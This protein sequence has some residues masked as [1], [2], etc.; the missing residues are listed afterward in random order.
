MQGVRTTRGCVGCR[1]RKKGCDLRKPICGRCS[2]LNITCHYEDQRLIFVDDGPTARS[3]VTAGPAAPSATAP[4]SIPMSVSQ[5]ALTRTNTQLQVDA[6]FWSIY[7]TK[8][9]PSL[10]GS[11]DGITSAPWI[12][13]V[14]SLAETDSHLRKTL[15]ALEFAGL[16]WVRDDRS[17]VQHSLRLYT[18]ALKE[19]NRALQNVATAQRDATLA[20]CRLLGLFEMLQRSSPR[21]RTDRTQVTDWQSHVDGTCRLIQL[22]GRDKHTSGHGLNLYDSIRITSIIHGIARRRPNAFT[23]LSWDLARPRTLKDE[24][25]DLM[26]T[27]PNLFQSIDRVNAHISGGDTGE[28]DTE[29]FCLA[30][31]ELLQR[32]LSTVDHLRAWEA[33]ALSLC[34]RDVP[35]PGSDAGALD[36]SNTLADVCLYHGEGFFFVC[37]QYWAMCVKMYTAN[38]L[39]YNQISS[40]FR[41]SAPGM[42]A[43]IPQLSDW[44]DPEP[45]AV[46]IADTTLHFFRSDAGLW[47]AQSAVFPV[48]TALFHFAQKGG[49]DSAHFRTMTD[50]VSSSRTGA[51]MRDFLQNIVDSK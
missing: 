5:G 44:M 6:G 38:R 32:C 27:V 40:F 3:R 51:V 48:G 13:T 16:G 43:L 10:D 7:L 15:S 28:A 31:V 36:E 25:F 21:V 34:R 37:T 22:R 19:T 29:D 50:A 1:R 45:H 20:C 42:S 23:C 46:N 18:D 30:C 14:R 41:T 11:I 2:G 4:P 8:E 9:D 47:S 49:R 24:L 17:L 12:P 35:S 39:F 33:R 26:S